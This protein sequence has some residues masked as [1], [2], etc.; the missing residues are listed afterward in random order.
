MFSLLV[1]MGYALSLKVRNNIHIISKPKYIILHLLD[2]LFF[3]SLISVF[4]SNKYIKLPLYGDTNFTSQTFCTLLLVFSWMGI[5][6]INIFIFPVVAYLSLSRIGEVNKAMGEFGTFYLL[7]S[8]ISII[9]QIIEYQKLNRGFQNFFSEFR[10]EYGFSYLNQTPFDLET[11]KE[12]C[13]LLGYDVIKREEGQ[14]INIELNT[15]N[16]RKYDIKINEDE[17]IQNLKKNFRE[18]YN[19]SGE[20]ILTFKG[21]ILEDNVIISQYGIKDGYVIIIFIR[22]ANN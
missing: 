1:T 10:N 12:I 22:G 9:L 8:Y 20:I 21:K 5:K 14:V 3:S 11:I 2:I 16:G 17:T 18:K 19:V 6:A 4:A 13:Q 15:P 7:F